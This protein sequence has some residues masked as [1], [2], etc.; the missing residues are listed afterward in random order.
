MDVRFISS[1][2]IITQDPGASRKLFVDA[3]GLPLESPPGDEYAFSE[4]IGG[5]KHFGVWPLTQAAQACF[6]TADWPTDRPLPQVSIEFDV[7]DAP[8]V[9]QAV[10]ELERRGFHMVHGP[11][12]EPWGQTVARLITPE[13]A[14]VGISF[15]PW[16]HPG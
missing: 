14:I 15:A 6:G 12:T 10:E 4:K 13:G 7:P 16:M 9:A 8:A 5:S 2:S 11:R 1:V 3:L